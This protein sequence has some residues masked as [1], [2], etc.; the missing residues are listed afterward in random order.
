MRAALPGLP[1][2]LLRLAGGVTLA[3]SLPMIEE[4]LRGTIQHDG[5]SLFADGEY[6]ASGEA[7]SEAEFRAIAPLLASTLGG[8]THSSTR[9]ADR[10]GRTPLELA[11]GR[12]YG[13]MV[14]MIEAADR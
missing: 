10:N 3:D 5:I 13:E 12:G 7:P 1:R 14:R 9:L 4:L 8:A 11:R 6:R 2:L